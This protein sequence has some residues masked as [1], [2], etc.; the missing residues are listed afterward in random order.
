MSCRGRLPQSTERRLRVRSNGLA[1]RFAGPLRWWLPTRSWGR[2]LAWG[3]CSA[4]GMR[5]ARGGGGG[6]GWR[7]GGPR[8]GKMGGG[9]FLLGGGGGGGGGF[10]AYGGGRPG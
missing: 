9:G 1:R 5:W 8:G 10:C 7:G 4:A 2:R 6:L 3:F